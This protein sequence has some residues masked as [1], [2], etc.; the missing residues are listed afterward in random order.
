VRFLQELSTPYRAEG[1]N[2]DG[3]LTDWE[4]VPVLK[5]GN[6]SRSG[7]QLRSFYDARYLYL[8][9]TVPNLQAAE[10][11]ESGFSDEIQIGMARRIS[12]TDF[13]GD[14]LRLGLN[15]NSEQANDRTPGRKA[16]GTIPGVRSVCRAE[17]L[18]TTYEVAVPLRLVRSLKAI[19]GGG[20]VVDLSF[21][22][23]EET[24]EIAETP[25]PNVNTFSY[26]IRYGSDSLVPVYFVELN[27][28][29]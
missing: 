1:P 29:R 17:A 25:E 26:R 7:A 18:R 22:T 3:K 13:A 15:S 4:E 5:L 24:A 11:K 19:E 12:D 23:P 16:E 2:L 9:I 8:A 6:D 21:P 20:L 10:A 27:L 28:E 14:L